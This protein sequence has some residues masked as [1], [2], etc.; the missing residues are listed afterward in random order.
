MIFISKWILRV[1]WSKLIMYDERAWSLDSSL[2][3]KCLMPRSANGKIPF[4]LTVIFVGFKNM[5]FVS[6]SSLRITSVVCWL[7]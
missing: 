3:E 6:Y 5:L 2:R 1:D 7:H 4:F